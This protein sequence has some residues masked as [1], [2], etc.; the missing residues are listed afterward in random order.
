MECIQKEPSTCAALKDMMSTGGSS[1]EQLLGMKSMCGTTGDDSG[2][3]MTCGMVK[4]AY[5]SNGCCQDNAMKKIQMP[6]AQF[7]RLQA[8][9]SLFAAG[10]SGAPLPSQF[11]ASIPTLRRLTAKK[12]HCSLGRV[13][14]GLSGCRASL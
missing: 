6:D 12:Q 13:P 5:K 8:I 7:R 9:P 4:Y 11:M 1:L 10:A 14:S 3:G 2:E